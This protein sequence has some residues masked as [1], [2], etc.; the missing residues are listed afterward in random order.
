VVWAAPEPNK[1]L[2]AAVNSFAETT[3]AAA[4][5]LTEKQQRYAKIKEIKT[6]AVEALAKGDAAK[7]HRRADRQ[8]EFSNLE[9]R[10]VRG[11]ILDGQPRID[12]RDTKTVR[13]S[14]S[15]P[16]CCRAPTARRCS[17]GA[18]PRPWWSRR[19]GTGRDEQII[20]ALTGER[21]EPF[22][23]HYNFPPLASAKPA[24][25]AR[26]SGARSATASLPSA[27]QGGD[28]GRG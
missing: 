20:D 3:L 1:E 11:K 21:K 16:A 7:V 12:G 10:L 13:P 26:P 23:L 24:A 19:L 27:R 15:A 6:A 28:A 22:M 25:W 9:Y 5:T 18:R 2:Q 14:I 8:A 17:P 4:Y